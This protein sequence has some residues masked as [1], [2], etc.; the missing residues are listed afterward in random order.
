M[1]EVYNSS[2]GVMLLV[3]HFITL[4]RFVVL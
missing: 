4:V 2:D 3:F 1:I